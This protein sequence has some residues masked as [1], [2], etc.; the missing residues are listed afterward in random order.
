M[1]KLIALSILILSG[2]KET[3]TADETSTPADPSGPV[4]RMI[5]SQGCTI[6]K[7]KSAVTINCSDGSSSS[8]DTTPVG[9]SYY[10]RDANGVDYPNLRFVGGGFF[11]NSNT[12]HILDYNP[13]TGTIVGPTTIYFESIN[14]TGNAYTTMSTQFSNEIFA[15][16]SGAPGFPAIMTTGVPIAGQSGLSYFNGACSNAAWGGGAGSWIKITA[17]GM[18]SVPTAFAMPIS[19]QLAQ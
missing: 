13:G 14:C 9:T 19:L 11:Y 5:Q 8:F 7:V 2:C 18:D 12:G 15:N 16:L 3:K 6:S 1:K 4:M 17:V 10:V